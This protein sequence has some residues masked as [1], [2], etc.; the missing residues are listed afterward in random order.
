MNND[1]TIIEYTNFH[2]RP[3]TFITNISSDDIKIYKE[4]IYKSSSP[5]TILSV[6]FDD[7]GNILENSHSLHLL[8]GKENFDLNYFWKIFNELYN[9]KA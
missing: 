4:A 5:L 6:A 2:N 3:K 8:P 7:S 1:E 9:N